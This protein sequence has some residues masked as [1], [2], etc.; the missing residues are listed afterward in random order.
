M[1]QNQPATEQPKPKIIQPHPTSEGLVLADQTIDLSW[2][3]FI[4]Q[5]IALIGIEIVLILTGGIILLNFSANVIFG[6]MFLLAIASL[7]FSMAVGLAQLVKQKLLALRFSSSKIVIS[8]FPL[9]LGEECFVRYYLQLRRGQ[10]RK[11][12]KL[13]AQLVC[14]EWVKYTVGTDT[15]T[16]TQKVW[17]QSLPAKDISVGTSNLEYNCRLQIPH[18]GSPSFEAQENMVYWLLEIVLDLPGLFTGTSSFILM[19][20]PEVIA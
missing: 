3:S 9:R 1:T 19:V 2:S 18:Q 17:E 13:T 20:E 7:I 5:S 10:T 8:K 11:L 12:G 6:S 14:Y 16:L 4:L 15:T